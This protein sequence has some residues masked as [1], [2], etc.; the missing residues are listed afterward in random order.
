MSFRWPRLALLAPRSVWQPRAPRAGIS[1]D[2]GRLHLAAE[3]GHRRRKVVGVQ[4]RELVHEGWRVG[5][6][7]QSALLAFTG[8]LHIAKFFSNLQLLDVG[9]NH[10]R[11]SPCAYSPY[12]PFL[13]LSTAHQ[14]PQYPAIPPP[15]HPTPIFSPLWSAVSSRPFHLF[16]CLFIISSAASE[17]GRGGI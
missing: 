9:A 10:Q 3:Q 17:L 13:P 6:C 11:G 1:L 16:M 7:C 2:G 5:G 4:A 8:S 14:A 15:P 12:H